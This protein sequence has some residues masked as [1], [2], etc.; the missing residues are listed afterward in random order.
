MN[1]TFIEQHDNLIEITPSSFY[2]NESD[3]SQN[4]LNVGLINFKGI[5]PGHL[6]V[7]AKTEPN[8]TSMLVNHKLYSIFKFTYLLIFLVE[9]MYLFG[10]Q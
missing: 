7:T 5:H 10:S 3:I 2:I 1:V 4:P 9:K 6:E 8:N